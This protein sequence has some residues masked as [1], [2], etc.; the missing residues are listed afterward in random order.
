MEIEVEEYIRTNEGEI[1]KIIETKKDDEY[2]YK[3]YICDND[4]GYLR[5]QIVNHSKNIINLLEVGDYVN[6]YK[7]ISIDRNVPDIHTDCIE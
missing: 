7:V 5:S 1:H 4:M 6:G 3:Y 2:S